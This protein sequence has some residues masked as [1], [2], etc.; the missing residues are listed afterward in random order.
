MTAP[1]DLQAIFQRIDAGA[2]LSPE[3]LDAVVSAARHQAQSVAIATG[4]GSVAIGGSADGAVIVTGDR[5]IFVSGANAEAIRLLL[6]IRPDYEKTFLT[7]VKGEVTSRLKQSLQHNQLIPLKME[8]HPEKVRR[9]WDAENKLGNRDPAPVPDA[10]RIEQVFD[11]ADGKLLILGK[12]GTGKTTLML[13]LAKVLCDRAQTQ[14]EA[15]IPVLLSLS[16]YRQTEQ[17]LWQWLLIELKSKYGL[18]TDLAE[19]L[20]KAQKFAVMLDGLDELPSNQQSPCI[21]NINQLMASELRVRSLLICSRQEEYDSCE[22]PLTLNGAVLLRELTDEQI[23][24]YLND[25]AQID[26]IA[27]LERDEALYELAHSPLLLNIAI[28]SRKE[29]SALG[30]KQAASVDERRTYLLEAYVQRML[31]REIKNNFYRKQQPPTKEQT[32]YWL[33]QVADMLSQSSQT[34]FI[35]ERL[36]PMYIKSRSGLAAYF[37]FDI[38]FDLL[39]QRSLAEYTDKLKRKLGVRSTRPAVYRFL[40]F[41]FLSSI[42]IASVEIITTATTYFRHHS[43]DAIREKLNDAVA[44]ETALN[45]FIDEIAFYDVMTLSFNA[46]VVVAQIIAGAGA[47]AFLGYLVSLFVPA[48]AWISPRPL[49]GGVFGALY[50]TCLG[51]FAQLKP[52]YSRSDLEDKKS[53][54]QGVRQVMLNVTKL[55]A[56]RFII[57]MGFC[58]LSALLA[59]TVKQDIRLSLVLGLVCLGVG[60]VKVLQFGAKDGGKAVFRHY[61][62]RTIL[63]YEGSI[64]RDYVRFLDYCTERQLLQRVGGRY[65]FFHLLLQEYFAKQSSEELSIN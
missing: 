17:S 8:F 63:Q 56:L 11:E 45:D 47:G 34:E 53:P 12:P 59:W 14:P 36:Q 50:A 54:G 62:L 38:M 42:T 13:D 21:E 32:Q 3:E 49:W 27:I 40:G 61:V 65:R 43:I 39:I 26:F 19:M 2:L 44:T 55:G 46:A 4:E 6:K 52:S 57:L 33:N 16:T 24:T 31:T 20:L 25:L 10:W 30:S 29:I 41:P 7:V 1:L 18:N 23:R 35:L 15:P 28:L 9:P 5:N 58:G 60:A 51:C 37:T 22:I 48:E 64:P